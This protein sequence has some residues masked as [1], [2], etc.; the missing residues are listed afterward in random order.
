MSQSVPA[1]GGPSTPRKIS[2]LQLIA[3]TYF[4]VCGGPYGLEDVVSNAGY[5]LG[6]IILLVIPLIWSLP[7][8]LMVSELS[9]AIPVDGGYYIWVRRALGP[10]WGF[11]EAWLSLA[12]SVFDMAIYPTLFIK[13]FFFLCERPDLA[14][15]PPP[16]ALGIGVML[17][18]VCV[19]ANLRGARTVGGSSLVMMAVLLGPFVALI[20]SAYASDPLPVEPSAKP[21]ELDYVAALV[22]AMFNYMGWD[23]TST[24]AGEVELPQR[25]Y[26][27]ALGGALLLVVLTYLLPVVAATRSGIDAAD[28]DTGSWVAV[29]RKVAGPVLGGAIAIGGM[30]SALGM[31]NS[32]VMSYSRLPLVMAQDGFLPAIFS[33]CH[34]RTGAPWVSILACA[35]VWALALQ[36]SLPR[37][38]ALDVILYGMSLMLEF[39]ALLVLRIRE[40]NLVRPFR[41][42]GGKLGAILLGLGPAVLIGVAI[43]DQ[44]GQWSPTEDDP[45]APAHG[46]MLGAVI[47]ALGPVVYF[48]SAYWR[49]PADS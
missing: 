21:T 34:P 19:A 49:R 48:G 17:I 40:P 30:I 22:L 27:L 31:F 18:V 20:V 38:L 9:T 5:L 36:L 35:A 1:S 26:P 28:W 25:T 24:I 33:R 43:Y 7:T 14:K 12:A 3:A 16:W 39:V 6:I 37:L 4:M 23:N 45:I 44:A 2:I 11:Q 15:V 13:Y 42:P 32:L 41:A 10:F 46:L 29:G 8:A 47:A